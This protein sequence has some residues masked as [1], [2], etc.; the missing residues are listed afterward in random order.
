MTK[1]KQARECKDERRPELASLR[2]NNCDMRCP[3]TVKSW[4][5]ILLMARVNDREPSV[6]KLQVGNRN[7]TQ[8]KLRSSNIKFTSATALASSI[9][10]KQVGPFKGSFKSDLPRFFDETVKSKP[11]APRINRKEARQEALWKKIEK[12]NCASCG[13]SSKKSTEVFPS[14][15]SEN[16]ITPFECNERKA[17]ACDVNMKGDTRPVWLELCTGNRKSM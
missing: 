17:S 13:S 1:S 3:E 7:S 14:E 10:S 11:I 4:T 16:S 6:T 15:S 8:P 9:T 2:T 5:P 12:S